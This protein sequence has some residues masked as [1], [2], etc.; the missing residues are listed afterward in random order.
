[1]PKTLV[2]GGLQAVD[3]PTPPHAVFGL[4]KTS[5]FGSWG[6]ML[7]ACKLQDAL[8]LKHDAVCCWRRLVRWIRLQLKADL[9][10]PF[11]H[12]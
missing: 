2:H 5:V 11:S 10:I 6:E 12:F 3:F 7:F 8:A 9:N 4:P 1:L